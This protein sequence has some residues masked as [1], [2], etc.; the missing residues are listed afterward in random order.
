MAESETNNITVDNLWIIIFYVVSSVLFIG[1]LIQLMLLI[2]GG[3]KFYILV[4][5]RYK[6]LHVLA[7]I[8]RLLS[9]IYFPAVAFYIFTDLCVYKRKKLF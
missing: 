9:I 6:I 4:I 3:E 1:T 7:Y 5:K 2:P 8:C